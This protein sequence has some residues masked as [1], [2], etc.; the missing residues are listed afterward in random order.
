MDQAVVNKIAEYRD[1]YETAVKYNQTEF[2][3]D[4]QPVLVS[5]AKYNLEHLEGKYGR[6]K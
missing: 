1:L 5:F 6:D 3:L 4:G 2:T